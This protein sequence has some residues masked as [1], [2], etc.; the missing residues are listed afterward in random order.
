[1]FG[2]GKEPGKATLQVGASDPVDFDESNYTE[3][4][5]GFQAGVD[6]LCGAIASWVSVKEGHRADPDTSAT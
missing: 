4:I 3:A 6:F 1:M 2:P 5:S